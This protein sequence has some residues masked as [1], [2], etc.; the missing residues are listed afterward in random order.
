MQSTNWD[1]LRFFLALFRGG[2]LKAAAGATGVN[3]TTVARR[4]RALEADL[5]V[6]LFLR[7]P[8]GRYEPTDAALEILGHAETMESAILALKTRPNPVSGVV[9]ITSVPFIINRVLVP[10]VRILTQQHPQLTVELVPSSDN[11]DLSKRQADLALRFARP[12]EGGLRVKAQKLGALRFGAYAA[13]SIPADEAEN[14]GWITYDDT[15]AS[16]PQAQW[17]E[18]AAAAPDTRRAGIRVADIETALEAT[19]NGLG[20]TLLPSLIADGDQRVRAVLPDS[21]TQMVVRD[22]WLLSHVDQTG[23]SSV[24]AAKQWLADIQ[25][26]GNTF[27]A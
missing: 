6:S 2:K 25:W 21:Q 4:V 13:Q 10:Q 18:K 19:A 1:D 20:K 15:S 23:R 14:L 9:R 24:A 5:G 12:D 11:L 3:E 16:L 26:S 8:A 22:V 17:L 7:S 27:A